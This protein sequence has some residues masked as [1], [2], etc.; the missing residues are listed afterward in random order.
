MERYTRLLKIDNQEFD[1][2]CPVRI[3]AWALLRD[4][5]L[6][7]EVAQLKLQ[8]CCDFIVHQVKVCIV[9]FDSYGKK[10]GQELFYV[11]DNLSVKTNEIFASD[12]AISLQDYPN[13]A[14]FQCT[15]VKVF[16][17]KDILWEY[18]SDIKEITALYEQ[19]IRREEEERIAGQY[20]DAISVMN[21]A[22]T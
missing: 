18:G 2:R 5:V 13:V 9:S 17:E 6:C 22:K 4:N 7:K 15:I 3:M 10:I 12:H 19:K 20:N 8:N 14:S 11:Y 21:T 16:M 1:E